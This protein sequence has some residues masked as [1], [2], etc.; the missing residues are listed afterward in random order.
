[1]QQADALRQKG[2]DTIACLAVNDVFVLDA[3]AKSTGGVGKISFLSDGNGDL[4]RRIGMELDAS[5]FGMG[6]RSKRYAMVVDDGVVKALLVEPQA[7]Q[8]LETSADKILAA[9]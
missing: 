9:L 1:V 5:G 7:G 4:T 3:W 8:A 6:M 2:V